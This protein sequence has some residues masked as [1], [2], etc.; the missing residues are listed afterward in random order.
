MIRWQQETACNPGRGVVDRLRRLPLEP[1]LFVSTVR[2]VA[3]VIIRS[4]LRV[5][6]RFEII[7][8]EKLRTNRPLIIVAN[9]SSHLDTLCL[10]AALPLRK[11]HCAFPVAAADYFFQSVG[12]TWFAS[13]VMNAL[14][15]GRQF[16][17]RRSLTICSELTNTP[18]NVLIIFPEGTRTTTG[19]TQQFKLGVG[20]LVAGRDVTVIPCYLDGT[21]RAWRK[22][23]RLPRPKKIRLIVG[24]PRNYASRGE[25]KTDISAI[26]AEL[27]RA[28]REL[29]ET[30]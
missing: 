22:G 12:R 4:L 7:G 24:E 18:G 26:A 30:T 20:A 21:F 3:A 1:N 6:N 19:R 5:Y 10:L 15:F 11:L 27:N 28:V 14:P 29:G 13:V 2:T 25:E 23:Q 9:H 17:I 16:H 8:P